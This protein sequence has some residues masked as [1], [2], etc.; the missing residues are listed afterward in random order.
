MSVTLQILNGDVPVAN[1][2]G[3]PITVVDDI[4]LRQAII[5][6]LETATRDN[7]FGAGIQSL[8]GTDTDDDDVVGML[9][10]NRIR[11]SF[12]AM[13]ILQG[14]PPTD[15]RPSKERLSSVGGITAI[16]DLTDLR[17]YRYRID[18]V[19]EAGLTVR[20]AGILAQE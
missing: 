14:L 16:R 3:R 15:V 12:I 11:Q 17:I 7:N 4:A 1:S 9:L 6:N 18:L 20:A 8:V 2:T 10:D 5:C 19:T 13:K